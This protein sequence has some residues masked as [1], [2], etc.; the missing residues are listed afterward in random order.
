[1]KDGIWSIEK[2]RKALDQA[3][4]DGHHILPNIIE[5]HLCNNTRLFYY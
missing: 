1:M 3:I 5:N 2:M 4:K